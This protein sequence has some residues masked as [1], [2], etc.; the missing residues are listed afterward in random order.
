MKI[1]KPVT[2]MELFLVI[3]AILMIFLL[4]INKWLS[5]HEEI[6]VIPDHNMLIRLYKDSLNNCIVLPSEY[7]DN[8]QWKDSII[9]YPMD[10]AY[11][12]VFHITDKSDD[13][14]FISGFMEPHLK[15]RNEEVNII[16]IQ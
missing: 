12:D 9:I 10:R 5:V 15:C 3:V 14:Y 2:G 7:S 4:K 1:D 11:C 16:E 13:N 8:L 6:Y